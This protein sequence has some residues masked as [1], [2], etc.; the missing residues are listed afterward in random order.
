MG[1]TFYIMGCRNGIH[2]RG[3]SKNLEF[4]W[5]ARFILLNLDACIADDTLI[6]T[7]GRTNPRLESENVML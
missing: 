6:E 5:V 2:K 3:R 1:P 7:K 4:N